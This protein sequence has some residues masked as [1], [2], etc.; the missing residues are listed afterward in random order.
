MDQWISF[1]KIS[2]TLAPLFPALLAPMRVSQEEFLYLDLRKLALVSPLQSLKTVAHSLVPA[3]L[4]P[5]RVA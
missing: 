5:M 2:T 4:A 1:S 3:L